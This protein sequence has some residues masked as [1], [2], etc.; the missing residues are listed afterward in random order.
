MEADE[1]I[2]REQVFQMIINEFYS[3]L[4]S[5]T[6]FCLKTINS[7]VEENVKKQFPKNY[8]EILGIQ[9]HE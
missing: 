8:K 2:K 1:L 3:N 5:E 4:D 9:E 7:I 6:P